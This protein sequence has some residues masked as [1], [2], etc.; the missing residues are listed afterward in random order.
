MSEAIGA[1]VVEAP[2]ENLGSQAA[3]Q[4][5]LG[6]APDTIH[7]RIAAIVRALPAIGKG[8]RNT[9]QN[10]M[11][12]GHDDVMNELN[13]LLSKYQVFFAPTVLER[14]TAQRT[15]SKGNVLYEVNLH[16][17]YAFFGPRGDFILASAWGEG[18][19]SGD[20]S[21]NKAMT[22]ALK[23][24]VAQVFAVSTE[25]NSRYDTDAHTD[26]ATTGRADYE[27]PTKGF[28]IPQSWPELQASIEQYGD[29]TWLDFQAL[30]RA[31]HVTVPGKNEF[32]QACAGTA[33]RLL[34]TH[35]PSDFPPPSLADLQA[36]WSP[37][38][39]GEVLTPVYEE[40]KEAPAPDV[41]AA[42]KPAEEAVAVEA[43]D[44]IPE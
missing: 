21:T 4:A 40:T 22:M 20:K 12:R 10:F 16:V 15:T 18:T 29:S 34:E 35:D 24:V 44:V 31:A 17:Q 32:W 36:A 30:M 19:D 39:A 13:P 9:Q 37:A 43:D 26:E 27:E 1:D 6:P 28:P 42:E 2:H 14:V 41:P 23:N 8:Q 5:T 38:V 11:Y 3:D 25:E 33:V 7:E